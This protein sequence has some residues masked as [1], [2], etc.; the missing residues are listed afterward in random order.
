MGNRLTLNLGLRT[1]DEKV[2]TFRPEFLENA[3]EFT[4]RATSS[5][6]G[7][8]RPTTCGATAA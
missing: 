7:S 5:R 4:L 3:F 2:P 8:A 1:E 6:R